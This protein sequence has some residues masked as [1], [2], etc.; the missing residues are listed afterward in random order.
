VLVALGG[1]TMLLWILAVGTAA[2]AVAGR[3]G[4]RGGARRQACASDQIDESA[5]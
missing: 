2:A 1:Y 3:L 5:Q 4:V